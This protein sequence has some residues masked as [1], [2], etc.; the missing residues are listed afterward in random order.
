MRPTPVDER[1]TCDSVAGHEIGCAS[2]KNA[3]SWHPTKYEV[4]G[5]RLRASK[6]QTY[7]G[8]GSRLVADRVAQTYDSRIKQHVAGR[9]L[10]LGCGRV[11]FY[12]AYRDFVTTC[13]CVDWNAG[14]HVDIEC[15]LSAPLPLADGAYDTILLS[16]VLEHIPDPELLWREIARVIAPGG[17]VI[18]NVPFIYSIHEQPHDYYRY[19]CYALERF[20][21]VNSLRMVEL[22]TTGGVVEVLMDITGKMLAKV[23]VAGKTLAA[24]VQ[25]ATLAFGHTRIGRKVADVS[26]TRFPLG[27]FLVAQRE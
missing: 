1:R 13:T 19:T 21:K 14:D 2:L 10:D 5:K 23:P 27:Y 25:G 15:D 26:A 17:K 22:T 12:G 3:D 6:D 20:V 18:V 11:P 16:D 8:V 7:L 9:M 24:G 4:R